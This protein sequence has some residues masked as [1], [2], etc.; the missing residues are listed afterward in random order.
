MINDI[1]TPTGAAAV[2]AVAAATAGSIAL[3]SATPP[4]FPPQGM[5]QPGVGV[6]GAGGVLPVAAIVVR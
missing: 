3:A 5:P 6:G 4:M 2:A 1:M